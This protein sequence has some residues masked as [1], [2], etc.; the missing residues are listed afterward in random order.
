MRKAE[1]TYQ[2]QQAVPARTFFQPASCLQRPSQRDGS[3]HHTISDLPQIRFN[4]VKDNP[5]Q[6]CEASPAIWYH[7]VLPAMRHR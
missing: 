6:S 1:L 5:S 7:T 2:A 4:K 3:R